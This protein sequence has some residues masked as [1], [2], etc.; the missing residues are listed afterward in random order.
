VAVAS[1]PPLLPGAP[2][3]ERAA[4]A[5]EQL[6]V[7][8]D[9]Y[10]RGLREP[11]PLYCETSAAYAGGGRAAETLARKAWT[12]SFGQAPREDRDDEHVR[13]L[14]SIAPFDDVLAPEPR[15]DE[16]GDGWTDDPTRLGRYAHRLWDGLLAV[17]EVRDQ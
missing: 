17:E 5:H 14:G 16:T 6:E 4:R 1:I 11:L 10:D 13:V 12:S 15:E 9:L 8:V 2:P 3:D 7:L